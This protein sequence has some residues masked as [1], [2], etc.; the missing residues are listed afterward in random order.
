MKIKKIDNFKISSHSTLG[1]NCFNERTFETKKNYDSFSTST[2]HTCYVS[3]FSLK[4]D[5]NLI[6]KLKSLK[7]L[8]LNVD[9]CL[10]LKKLCD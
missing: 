5:A 6:G 7:F 4:I 10:Y 3:T 9:E 1:C 2:L 8:C